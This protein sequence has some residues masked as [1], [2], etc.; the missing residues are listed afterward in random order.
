MTTHGPP[1]CTQGT[2]WRLK[3][4]RWPRVVICLLFWDHESSPIFNVSYLSQVAL[5]YKKI[6]ISLICVILINHFIQKGKYYPTSLL[7]MTLTKQ[8]YVWCKNIKYH[9]W[10]MFNVFQL[11]WV[12]MIFLAQNYCYISIQRTRFYKNRL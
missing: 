5:P 11:F 4:T 8:G 9:S 10:P 1:L 3:V 7:K 12:F 6:D 2:H